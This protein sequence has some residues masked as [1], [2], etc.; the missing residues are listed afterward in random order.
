MFNRWEE[1]STY[2]LNL[3]NNFWSA[4]EY[5]GFLNKFKYV[6]DRVL[7]DKYTI[8]EKKRTRQIFNWLQCFEPSELKSEFDSYGLQV[9]ELL[10]DVA[11]KAYDPESDEFAVVAR[12]VNGK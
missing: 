8:V 1:S 2:E 5:F 11:G 3:L 6:E 12:T 7:L 10:G 9:V 4:D